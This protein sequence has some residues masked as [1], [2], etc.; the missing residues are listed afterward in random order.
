MLRYLFVATLVSANL[1]WVNAAR[2]Q[3]LTVV[4]SQDNTIFQVSYASAQQISNGAGPGI[5]VG[6]T[7]QGNVRRGL[8]EFNLS[9]IPAGSVVTNVQVTLNLQKAGAGEATSTIDLNRVTTAWGE[10]ASNSPQGH[11]A[12][13]AA[14]D[15]SWYYSKYST[16]QWT[17]PG[18][19]FVST[20][21]ASTVVG[22]NS[23]QNYTWGSTSALVSDVQG[24]IN[25]PSTNDGWIVI[26]DESTAQSA[27]EFASIAIG[28]SSLEPSLT[29]TYTTAVP[30]PASVLLIALLGLGALKAVYGIARRRREA[31]VQG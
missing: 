20:P 9:A 16:V 23:G 17:T 31:V 24:W 7:N 15:A 28:N 30:E 1:G 13:S 27:R 22:S 8:I 10:G 6:L 12:N 2:A 4:A 21:S 11:G 26:G 18:G 14:G 5:F 29:I 19:D 3:T 25:K